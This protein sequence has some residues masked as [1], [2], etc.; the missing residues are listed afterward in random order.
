MS[1]FMLLGIL[2]FGLNPKGFYSTNNV[3]WIEGQTGIR[4]GKYGI[5]Y[6]NSPFNSLATHSNTPGRLSIETAIKPDDISNGGFRFLLALHSGE[7]SKQL[8]VGQWL[9][10]IIIMNVDNYEN[11]KKTKKIAVRGTLNP[12]KIR[13]LT[14]TSGEDGTQVYLDGQFEKREKDLVLVIPHERVENWL[15]VG[16]SVYGRHSWTGDIYGLALYDRALTEKDVA[17]HFKQWSKERDF[18]FA[19]EHAPMVLYMFDEKGGEKAFNQAGEN[20]HLEIPSQMPILQRE[21]LITPWHDFELNQSFIQD[22]VINI[23]GFI[24]FSFF[25]SALLKNL[26]GFLERNSFLIVVLLCL[27]LSLLIEI[28]QAWMPSRSSQ[29]LDVILNTLGGFVG[30]IF[31]RFFHCLSPKGSVN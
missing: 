4:F 26:G 10:W 5:A 11:K 12:E 19:K 7:D 2:Y 3:M 8:L 9:S 1:V 23:I 29:M 28:A 21:I 6:T 22:F 30:A 20:H 25:L 17:L 14:I 18:S 24:P 27:V 13:F 31:N 16:N 15:V